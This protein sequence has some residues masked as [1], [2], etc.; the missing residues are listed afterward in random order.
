M[1]TSFC[2]NAVNKASGPV[3]YTG[4]ALHPQL[5]MTPMS[6]ILKF[7]IFWAILL[8]LLFIIAEFQGH[9]G[10]SASWV[11]NLGSGHD[12]VVCGFEPHVRLC[13]DSS[14]PEA[15]FGFCASQLMLCLSLSLKNKH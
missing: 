10:G 1:C 8:S 13:A 7:L 6:G 2:Y 5:I 12:L 11:S 14:E 4:I 15:Y 3:E 9:L